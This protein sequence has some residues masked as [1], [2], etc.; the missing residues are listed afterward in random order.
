MIMSEEEIIKSYREAAYKGSQIG[1][2]ADLNDCKPSEIHAVLDKHGI[3]ISKNP[4]PTKRKRG[5]PAA[6][7]SIYEPE[8]EIV[9]TDVDK[10]LL[11]L[12]EEGIVTIE[13]EIKKYQSMIDTLEK[14]KLTF[15]KLKEDIQG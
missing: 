10:K 1:I 3:D 2:L 7:D 4:A 6:A 12:I 14:R 13:E 9:L 5:R 8:S 15:T 11:P